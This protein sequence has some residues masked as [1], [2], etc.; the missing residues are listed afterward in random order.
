MFCGLVGGAT[1]V[2]HTCA[3]GAGTA[4][5]LAATL[6]SETFRVILTQKV[7]FSF[8]ITSVPRSLLGDPGCLASPGF[9]STGW[10]PRH[11]RPRD[12]FMTS[13]SSCGRPK[14]VLPQSSPEAV[15]AETPSLQRAEGHMSASPPMN[16]D[17]SGE[18]QLRFQMMMFAQHTSQQGQEVVPEQTPPPPNPR[19]KRLSRSARLPTATPRARQVLSLRSPRACLIHCPSLSKWATC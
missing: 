17:D 19:S 15:G 12:H 4:H 13:A 10:Q 14:I 11:P 1:G 7:N 18:T 5:D 6:H 16:A 8:T 9:R 2:G 3:C